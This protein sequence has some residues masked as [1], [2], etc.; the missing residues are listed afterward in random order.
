MEKWNSEMKAERYPRNPSFS[1]ALLDA[2]DRSTDEDDVGASFCVCRKTMTTTTTAAVMQGR[3]NRN[4]YGTKQTPRPFNWTT[5][6]KKGY[7]KPPSRRN[8]SELGVFEA[9]GWYRL[10]SKS[11]AARANSS[12]TSS[13]SESSGFSSSDADSVL[14]PTEKKLAEK[15][16]QY[17][18]KSRPPPVIIP[19]K[20]HHSTVAPDLFANK[21]TEEPGKSRG[22]RVSKL[23]N[24][25]KKAKQP[26][27][28]GSRIAS[29]LNSLFAT[30]KK[31]KLSSAA[32]TT[33]NTPSKSLS[34]LPADTFKRPAARA[35][36]TVP[37]TTTTP[38]S[39]S[40]LSKTRGEG[41]KS[42]VR[43]F[44]TNMTVGVGACE[45]KCLYEELLSSPLPLPHKEVKVRDLI[46]D[47]QM[48]STAAAGFL[49]DLSPS[50]KLEVEEEDGDEDDDA[51][52]C[53]SSDLFE[54]ENLT[55]LPVYETTNLE[56]N[57]AIAKGLIL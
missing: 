34:S 16:G 21:K 26:I 11:I 10:S 27:S 55:E 2:I 30:G 57:R 48:K 33:V 50:T 53:S 25:L 4:E 17:G 15:K 14:S 38:F 46:A 41:V 7:S 37:T 24:E 18:H 47:Y 20:Q 12:T 8:V 39:G 23:Y 44:P 51:T 13:S 28:P 5:D 22:I 29:F 45:H 42:S 56:T 52:S 43:F 54:L 31:G 40:C 6:E 35:S 49:F 36:P 1:S 32:A 9:A 3:P 19:P